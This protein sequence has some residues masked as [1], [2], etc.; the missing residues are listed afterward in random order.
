[1]KIIKHT[2]ISRYE[3]YEQPVTIE[4]DDGTLLDRVLYFKKEPFEADINK[5]AAD[6]IL[7]WEE[8]QSE[9]ERKTMISI[10]EVEAVLKGKGLMQSNEKWETWQTVATTLKDIE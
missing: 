5:S 4:L 2:P 9:P 1:M 3:K 7:K 8:R 10:E 6:V